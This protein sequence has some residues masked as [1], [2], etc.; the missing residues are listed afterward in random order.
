MQNGNLESVYWA[1]CGIGRSVKYIQPSLSLPLLSHI[2]RIFIQ[3]ICQLMGICIYVGKHLIQILC[4]H[5]DFYI[6]NLPVD[7][8]L[9][10]GKDHLI[11]ISLLSITPYWRISL[12]IV[13]TTYLSGERGLFVRFEG[14]LFYSSIVKCF[15]IWLVSLC[16]T[17]SSLNTTF[18]KSPRNR[19]M[20]GPGVYFSN[21]SDQLLWCMGIPIQSSHAFYGAA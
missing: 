9:V 17:R 2:A 19:I 15:K 20:Q 18:P 3:K 16:Y 11:H 1:M 7:G 21:R 12:C 13:H 5:K 10:S 14:C 6:K 4:K 8:H